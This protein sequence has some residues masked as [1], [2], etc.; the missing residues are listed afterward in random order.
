MIFP[1]IILFAK[2]GLTGTSQTCCFAGPLC[3]GYIYFV[4]NKKVKK[5]KSQTME[6]VHFYGCLS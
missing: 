4:E 6:N 2:A 1:A 3:I 5:K